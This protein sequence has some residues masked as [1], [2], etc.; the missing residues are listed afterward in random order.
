MNEEEKKKLDNIKYRNEYS[1]CTKIDLDFVLNLIEK[2][3]KE[4]EELKR[5]HIQDN[6]P[7]QLQIITEKEIKYHEKNILDIET[8]NYVKGQ[9]SQRRSGN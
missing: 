1:F 3:Q 2:L 4:N 9:N 8:Y 6:K 7:C 5:L